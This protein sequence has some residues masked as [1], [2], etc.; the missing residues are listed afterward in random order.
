MSEAPPVA[1]PT[2][3]WTEVRPV[4][5]GH[6]PMM[7]R[8]LYQ[9]LANKPA[10]NTYDFGCGMGLWLRD[11]SQQGLSRLFGFEGEPPACGVFPG[12]I[13]QDLTEKFDVPEPGNV[14][15]LEVCEHVPVE[16]ETQLLNNITRACKEHLVLSWAV[17]KM[18]G[19]GHV[20]CQENDYVIR[21]L[22]ERGFGFLPEETKMGR[23]SVCWLDWYL[24]T[25]MV[26]KRS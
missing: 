6:D 3:F 15:C 11:L 8:W 21:K 2:G 4:H 25:L 18:G 16:F 14:I 26:F 1:S 22:A 5:H 19:V 17:P 9:Y 24:D 12:V 7:A 13:K 10:A 23:Q 20:N